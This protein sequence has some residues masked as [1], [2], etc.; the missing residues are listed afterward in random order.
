VQ[1][2]G[3]KIARTFWGDAWCRHLESFSDFE[4]R[5]PRGRTYVRN[6]S[7]CH[8]EIARGKIKAIVSGS[9]LYDVEIEIR[10]LPE[11]KWIAVKERC[12]GKIGS[13]LELLQG[14]LSSSVMSI[15]THR[16]EGLF[17]LPAEI[18]MNC[19]CPDWAVMCK[20]VAATLYGV[21][22]RFDDQP[23]LLFVLRGVDHD[24]LIEADATTLMSRGGQGGARRIADD[25]LED[26]FGIEM[27]KQE[28]PKRPARSAGAGAAPLQGLP[29]RPVRNK[30]TPA[31]RRAAATAVAGSQPFTGRDVRQLRKK[32]EMSYSQLAA[33]LGVSATS[34]SNWEKARGRLN[35]QAR[36]R[37]A[38]SATMKL[39]K[40]Q[41]W[42]KL[43]KQ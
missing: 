34:V 22:A 15:V 21:G 6:G 32:L 4:N 14:K 11:N 12:A 33:L 29:A 20:H 41:A 16:Q 2:D 5:L 8:L 30:E 40:R 42:R 1:I 31:G 39:T 27:V 28:A 25:H 38:L 17:P 26:L 9:E 43:E 3:R 23:E 10:P 35:L 24:E 36:T 37:T 7:V 13:L 19:S 18:R